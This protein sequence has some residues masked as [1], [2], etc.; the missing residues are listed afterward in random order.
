M[1]KYCKKSQGKLHFTLL[2]YPPLDI[3][4]SNVQKMVDDSPNLANY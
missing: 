4:E 2:K 1:F 3:L